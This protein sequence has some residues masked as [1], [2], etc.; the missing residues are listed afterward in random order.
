M[1]SFVSRRIPSVAASLFSLA[2]ALSFV[3]STCDLA[4]DECDEPE[5]NRCTDDNAAVVCTRPGA[6]AHRVE[7]R[8][9]CVDK[10]VCT[11]GADHVP[12]CARPNATCTGPADTRCANGVV[13]TCRATADGGFA[14]SDE[15]CGTLMPKC[16]AD[17]PICVAK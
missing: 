15:T 8:D 14:W 10:T 4:A 9:P 12:F 1:P 2:L 16:A 17:Q 6:E 7:R 13:S 5:S 11:M 3:G